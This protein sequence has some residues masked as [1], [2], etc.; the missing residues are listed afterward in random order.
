MSVVQNEL[1]NVPSYLSDASTYGVSSRAIT[2]NNTCQSCEANPMSC[3]SGESTCNYCQGMTCEGTGQ[4]SCHDEECQVHLYHPGF[5]EPE[6]AYL[7]AGAPQ[8]VHGH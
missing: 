5:P 3:G 6:R 8:A 2:C 1:I 4:G 7:A